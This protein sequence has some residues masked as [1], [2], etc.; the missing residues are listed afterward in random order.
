MPPSFCAKADI[1]V[2][3][4]PLEIDRAQ[5]VVVDDREINRIAD[6]GGAPLLAVGAVTSGAVL[7]VEHHRIEHVSG[8]GTSGPGVGLPGS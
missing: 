1:A 4:R 6:G 3:G 5:R 7:A 2:P 8:L